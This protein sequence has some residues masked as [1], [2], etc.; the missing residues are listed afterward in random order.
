MGLEAVNTPRLPTSRGALMQVQNG[1][2]NPLL[3]T[4]DGRHQDSRV[5]YFPPHLLLASDPPSLARAKPQRSLAR[6]PLAY[7]SRHFPARSGLL[8]MDSPASHQMAFAVRL[9]HRCRDKHL[10]PLKHVVYL[11]SFPLLL[12]LPS[13]ASG[14]PLVTSSPGVIHSF[15]K[16][17]T[18]FSGSLCFYE[19]SLQSL[20]P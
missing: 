17:T 12:K 15:H 18:T 20:F 7:R 3:R 11:L 8:K 4:L 13:A 1:G 10:L 6:I 16:P 9:Y 14:H 19:L 5:L 2:T